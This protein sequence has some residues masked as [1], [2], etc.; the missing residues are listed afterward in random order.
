[1]KK[2]LKASAIL[3]SGLLIL[4]ACGNALPENKIIGTENGN[5]IPLAYYDKVFSQEAEK[6]ADGN[7]IAKQEKEKNETDKETFDKT[8]VVI[9]TILTPILQTQTEATVDRQKLNTAIN[10]LKAQYGDT[11]LEDAQKR[12]RVPIETEQDL[13]RIISF[14]LLYSNYYER[15]ITVTDEKISELYYEKYKTKYDAEHILIEKEADAQA[16]L[17]KIKKGEKTFADYVAEA[18][19]IAEK[20]AEEN[21]KGQQSQTLNVKDA[22][23]S[24]VKV[25]ELSDL[26]LQPASTYVGPF[27][28]ALK[29]M[30]PEETSTQLVKTEFGYHIIH[31]K[32]IEDNDLTK[33]LQND[34][35]AAYINEQEAQPGFTAHYFK[36][37]VEKVTLEISDVQVKKTWDE[38]VK[39]QDEDAKKYKPEA[40][41]K[42]DETKKDEKKEDKKHVK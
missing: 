40:A 7:P 32:K 29:Q 42:K 16:L 21:P 11:Y 15:Q 34:I 8:S 24:G 39:K 6:D 38:Y 20:Q 9:S 5:N 4:G 27:A 2:I 37:L 28:D 31:L 35:K 25:K 18:Q 17:D 26:G 22:T 36:Q 23:I 41:D 33:K 12:Y 1:M 3:F 14:Q 13:I 30:K 19:Q 10:N